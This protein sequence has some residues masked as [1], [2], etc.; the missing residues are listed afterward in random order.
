MRAIKPVAR[1][2]SLEER[3][4]DLSEWRALSVE[5]RLKA[6]WEM[7]L[8]WARLELEEARKRGEAP[9]IA[10]DRLLPVARK[11]PLR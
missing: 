5:E 6:V 7:A 2:F 1:R 8:F 4:D 10:L 11:R 3:P 9:E